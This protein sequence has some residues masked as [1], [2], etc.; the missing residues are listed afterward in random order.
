MYAS[1]IRINLPGLPHS[2]LTTSSMLIYIYFK[3]GR[4]MNLLGRMQLHQFPCCGICMYFM[5]GPKSLKWR[6][7]CVAAGGMV[8]AVVPSQ[9]PVPM[10]PLGTMWF[11]HGDLAAGWC[12]SGG[13]PGNLENW[14]GLE[15][16]MDLWI[17]TGHLAEDSGIWF[18][19][20]WTPTSASADTAE[21]HLR[22]D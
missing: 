14:Q 9:Q 21:V 3:A 12:L 7:P 2:I 4:S 20:G 16:P 5:K 11:D 13:E 6:S 22:M 10:V 17:S 19:G 15:Q 18:F 1:H 8:C